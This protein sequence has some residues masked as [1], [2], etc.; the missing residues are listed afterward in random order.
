MSFAISMAMHDQE[1]R[2]CSCAGGLSEALVG[3]PSCSAAVWEEVGM[4]EQIQAFV[5]KAGSKSM[6]F[7][8]GARVSL[9][10]CSRPSSEKRLARDS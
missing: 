7:L 3:N 9:R 4:P 5:D 2:F 8:I 6:N 10:T 1:R